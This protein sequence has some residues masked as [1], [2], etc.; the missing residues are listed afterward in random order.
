MDGWMD[1]F[2]WT[3]GSYV[4]HNTPP[5]ISVDDT[6]QNDSQAFISHS[7]RLGNKRTLRQK[8]LSTTRTGS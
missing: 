6:S 5:V 8:G 3:P 7:C 2:T 4:A 1:G